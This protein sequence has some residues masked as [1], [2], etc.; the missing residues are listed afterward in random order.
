MTNLLKNN[1]L[2]YS[3]ASLTVPI[4]SVQTNS[5]ILTNQIISA[6]H[7]FSYTIP[8]NSFT[9]DTLR[10]SISQADGSALPSWLHFDSTT[11]TLSGTP[12]EG[13][14]GTLNLKVTATDN[15]NA[16]VSSI[17][18]VTAID[19][20]PT[21]SLNGDGLITTDFNSADDV[22]VSTKIQADGKIIIAGYSYVGSHW[23]LALARYNTDGSL[24]TSFN[25]NGK[26]TTAIG[27]TDTYGYSVSI[28]ADGKILLA[29]DNYNGSTDSFALA[30]YNTDGSLDTSFNGNGIVTTTIGTNG[31]WANSVTTQTD[32]KILLAGN[33]LDNNYAIVLARFNSDGTLDASFNG[34]GVVKTAIGTSDN[35]GC[36][37]NLQADGKMLVVGYS[38]NGSK[39]GFALACYNGDG[40]LDTSFNATGEIITTIGTADAYAYASTLQSDGKILVAG[41]T[42]NGSNWDFALVRYN[43]D[44]SLDASFNGNGIVT[45]AIGSADDSAESIT[46][47]TDGKILVAGISNN[48]SS[49]DFALVRYNSDGSL[50]TTFNDTG[51]VTSDFGKQYAR[52]YSVTVQADGEILVAGRSS[53]GSNRDF[54][55]ARYNPD[56]TLDTS[57]HAVNTL[58][59]AN[60]LYT[61]NSVPVVLDSTVQIQDAELNAVGNYAGASITL[62][63]HG[64]ADSQDIF[65]ATGNLS[66]DGSNVLLSGVNIGVVSNSNGLLQVVFNANATQALVNQ[67]LSALAYSSNASNLPPSIQIDWTFNDGNSGAQGAG[68]TQSVTGISTVTINAPPSDILLDNNSVD[69]YSANGTVIGLLS[70][71]DKDA[72]QSH[73]LK[74]LDDAGGS[75]VL[76]GNK[77]VVANAALLDYESN[78]NPVVKIL[79][80]DSGGLS[81]EKDITIHINPFDADLVVSNIADVASPGS[82]YAGTYVDISWTDQNQYNSNFNGTWTDNVYLEDTNNPGQDR[83]LG[84]YNLTA[85]LLQGVALNRTQSVYLP[86]DL[87]GAYQL[88]VV[89]DANNQVKEGVAGEVNNRTVGS[90][91]FNIHPALSPNLQVSSVSAP[92]TIFAGKQTSIQ[93]TVTNSGTA[94]TNAPYWQDKVWLSLDKNLDG[95]DILLGTAN[96]PAYLNI[97]DSYTNQLNIN[98]PYTALGNYYVIVQTDAGNQIQEVGH[99]NDNANASNVMQVNPVPISDL[100]DLTVPNVSAPLQAFS[101]QQMLVGYQIGNQGQANLPD[102]AFAAANGLPTGEFTTS[103]PDLI[104]AQPEAQIKVYMSS[105]NTLSTDDLLLATQTLDMKYIKDL[106]VTY[107][108]DGNPVYH[109]QYINNAPLALGKSNFSGTVA[110]NLP[111]GVSGDFYYLVSLQNL[112]GPDAQTN[113]KSGISSAVHVVL[114]PPPDLEITGLTAPTSGNAGHQININYQVDNAGLTIT[115]NSS[116]IDQFYLSTTPTLASDAISLGSSIH[117]G[118][119]EV[120]GTYQGTVTFT[121]PTDLIGSYYLIAQTDSTNQVFEQNKVNNVT[122]IPINLVSQQP[123]LVV[124]NVV[125]DTNLFAGQ[126]VQVSWTVSNQGSGDTFPDSWQDTVVLSRDSI[127]GNADDIVLQSFTHT[128][129]L[130]P[131]QSYKQS[132]L[133]SLPAAASG[134]YYVFVQTDSSNNVFEG[135]NEQNNQLLANL[136]NTGQAT[137]LTV[138]SASADLKV[139]DIVVP[140][141]TA[142]GSF[143]NVSWTVANTGNASTN[144]NGW[145]DKIILSSDDT[146]GNADDIALGSVYRDNSLGVGESY[147]A[148]TNLLLPTALSGNYHVFVVA[149]SAHQVYEVGGHSDNVTEAQAVLSVAQTSLPD[150]QIT[151]L[152]VPATGLSTQTL[153]I[154]WTVTNN[155][156]A[157]LG[158]SDPAN[159]L[160]ATTRRDAFYLSRDQVLD[161]STDIYLGQAENPAALASGLSQTYSSSF[162][163]PRGLSGNY[164]LIAVTDNNNHLFEGSGE[165][166]NVTPSPNPIAI[167]LPPPADLAVENITIPANGLAGQQTSVQYTV[168][169]LSGET[170][171]GSWQDTLYLSKDNQW[172]I[173]DPVFAQVTHNGDLTVG[174]SY[175]GTV[176][177]FLPGVIPD[178]YHIIVRNDTLNNV[179]DLNRQNNLAASSDTINVDVN[180]LSLGV[181]ASGEI[182]QGQSVYY[183]LN[184]SAGQ[185]LDVDLKN[186]TQQG[187][188]ELYVSYNQMPTRT[189]F[190]YSYN[191][192]SG[193]EQTAVVPN[194]QSGTYYI[195]AYG[196]EITNSIDHTQPNTAAYTLSADLAHYGVTSISTNAGSNLGETTLR[197]TGTL[198]SPVSVASLVAADGTQISAKQVIWKN[199]TEIWATFDLK[200]QSIGNYDVK[201]SDGVN[202]ASLAHAFTV[203]HN[204]AGHLDISMELPSVLRPYQEGTARI[205]YRNTGSTDISAPLLTLSGDALLKLPSDKQYGGSS[206]ELL[207][208]NTDGPAGVIPP[209]GVGTITVNFKPFAVDAHT[210]VTLTISTLTPNAVQDWNTLLEN[211]KP[212]D[213]DFKSW[214]QIKANLIAEIGPTTDSYQQALNLAAN[215]LAQLGESTNDVKK[216]FALLYNE[217]SNNGALLHSATI[218][219]LGRDHLFKWDNNAIRQS[220]GDVKITVS[221]VA[222]QFTHQTDGRYVG[223]ASDTLTENTGVLTFRR[224]D[225][226]EIVFNPDGSFNTLTDTNGIVWHA[227]YSGTLLTSVS[228][229][230]GNSEAFTYNDQGRIK[231]ITDQANQTTIFGY[232]PSGLFQ[233]SVTTASGTTQYQY[234]TDGGAAQGQIKEIISPDGTVQH[235]NY[236]NQGRLY[237]ESLNND[238]ISETYHY[239]GV[240]EVDITD[241]KGATRKY[242]YNDQKQIA[243]IE[244]A[245]GNIN[246]LSYDSNG[247]I[248]NV[249]TSD[250]AVPARI[251]QTLSNSSAKINTLQ[252][253]NNQALNVATPTKYGYFPYPLPSVDI[254]KDTIT[255]FDIRDWGDKN[256]VLIAGFKQFYLNLVGALLQKGT[257]LEHATITVTLNIHSAQI[258]TF[259][260]SNNIILAVDPNNLYVNDLAAG[261]TQAQAQ[262]DVINEAVN[263]LV[264]DFLGTTEALAKSN[265]IVGSRGLVALD[266]LEVGIVP[267]S[268]AEAGAT[269]AF[270]SLIIASLELQ[271]ATYIAWKAEMAIINA[272]INNF[273]GVGNSVTL[274][275]YDKLNNKVSGLYFPD[276]LG[277]LGNDPYR[278]ATE[279][280][281]AQAKSEIDHNGGY[282]G[283]LDS[284]EAIYDPFG[285]GPIVNHKFEIY[286]GNFIINLL[287]LI[288]LN[289]GEFLNLS[290]KKNLNAHVGKNGEDYFIFDATAPYQNYYTSLDFKL[291]IGDSF[292]IYTV[293]NI[294]KN[295]AE[296]KDLMLGKGTGGVDL[297]YDENLNSASVLKSSGDNAIV[298]GGSANDVIYGHGKNNV[299][300]GNGGDDTFDMI[301][302]GDGT[303]VDGGQGTDKIEFSSQSHDVN[304]NLS[305]NLAYVKNSF[306][307]DNYTI[308]NVEDVTT[309]SGNDFVKG[310]V[311][312]SNVIKT[313]DGDDTLIGG[314]GD[315]DSHDTLNGGNGDDTYY[316]TSG[317]N[318]KDSDG[319]GKVYLDNE[320]L[321]GGDWQ[322]NINAFSDGKF[323]YVVK[324]D[325]ILIISDAGVTIISAHVDKSELL[326]GVTIYRTLGIELVKEKNPPTPPTPEPPK[327]LPKDPEP[328]QPIPILTPGD[329]NDIIGPQGYGDQNWLKAGATEDYTINFEN[330]STA[331]APAQQVTITE[332]LDPNLDINSFRLGDFGWG[333]ITVHVPTNASFYNERLDYS[334]KGYLL[335]VTAGIDVAKR[336]VFWTFT[337]LDPST[338]APTTNPLLG[339]L[340][341]NNDQGIGNAFV[342]YSISPNQKVTT[343]TSIQSKATIVFDTQPAM[344]TPTVAYTLDNTAPA[345]KLSATPIVGSDP[346]VNDYQ[347]TWSG[348][349]TGSA[350]ASYTL[351]VSDNGGAYKP[352]L[353]NSVLTQAVYHGQTGHNYA[354]YSI[355]V[356]NA[357]NQEA[358]PSAPQIAKVEPILA[359]R[360]AVGDNMDITVHFNK[361]VIVQAGNLAPA[362]SLAIGSGQ[363]NADYLSGSGTD[364]LVFRH[365]VQAGEYSTNGLS[366]GHA[367]VLNGSNI[368]D[369]AGNSADLNLGT[370]SVSGVSV[371]NAPLLTINGAAQT[372]EGSD[373][374]LSI[375]T[376]DADTG[377]QGLNLSIDWGDGSTQTLSTSA[378]AATNGVTDHVFTD[379]NNTAKPTKYNIQITASDPLGV[380]TIQNQ[381]ITVNN[382]A[383][384]IALSGNAK[385][386]QGQA[387]QLTLGNIIDPGQDTVSQITVHWGDG[388]Q[389]IYP[390]V[391]TVSHFYNTSA[392]NQIS[393]D[394]TDEDGQYTNVAHLNVAVNAVG[395]VVNFLSNLNTISNRSFSINDSSVNIANNLNA[396]ETNYS[397]INSITSFDNTVITLTAAQLTADKDVLALLSPSNYRLKVTGILVANVHTV[398]ANT[399]VTALTVMGVS[400]AN[401]DTATLGLLAKVSSI[402]L[403]SG[404]TSLTYAEYANANGKL[405]ST[406]LTITGVSVANAATVAADSHVAHLTLAGTALTAAQ[407]TS[408]VSTKNTTSGLT[409]TGVSV[410]NASTSSALVKDN[411]VTAIAVT[412]ATAINLDK[413]SLGLQTKVTS[414]TL[415]SGVTSLTYFEYS[416]A[417]GKLATSGI[418]IKGVPAANAAT[419]AGNTHV[420][421]ITLAG[422]ALKAVQYTSAVSAKNTT[423][424]LTINSVSVANASNLATDSHVASINVTGVSAT[425]LDTTTL[426]ALPKVT[427]IT[428]ATGVASL[429]YAEYVNAK[430]KLASTGLTITGV[431]VANAVAASTVVKDSHVAAITVIG[432]T[433]ANLDKTTLGA[434]SKVTSIA[435]VSGVTRLTSAEYANANGKLVSSGLIITGV[436]VA[437]AATVAADSHV[438]H[439]TLAGTALTAIQYISAVSTKNTTTGLTITGVDMTNA[440]IVAADSHVTSITVTGVGTTNLDTT[441][442]GALPKVTSI[443]LATGVAS[444]NYAEYV[445]AKG[446]LASTGLTITGVSV[447]NGVAT[448]TVIKDSHV[449]AITVNDTAA[450]IT[451]NL[452][453]L[454]T[455]TKLSSITLI[456]PTTALSITAVQSSANHAVLAKI[457]GAYNS[458]ITGTNV[459][460]KLFDTVN[461]HATLTGGKGIDTFNVTGTDTITDLG[462]GGAD[463]LIVAKGGITNSTINTAWI[464][465]A[466]TINNGTA[467]ISTAG[468]TV[469]LSAVTKGTSGYKIIDTGSATKLTGSALADLIIGGTGNDTLTGGKGNDVF[470]FNTKPNNTTNVDLITDFT[471]GKDHLQLGKSIFTGIFTVAGTGDGRTLAGTEFVSS[472]TATHGTTANSHLIYN[473]ATGALYYDADGNAK[474]AAI[475]VAILGTTTH[476]VLTASD[477]LII[478]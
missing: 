429:N 384:S 205:I 179:G 404:V 434:Q 190:D 114:T 78:P 118:S 444:L 255:A 66:F 361:S 79:S 111:T 451:A 192:L 164:Y 423:T 187:F 161:P 420:S 424:G 243:Q 358:G 156:A 154:G 232:D 143:L 282:L 309:G 377:N 230:N 370:I 459:A 115:P 196:Q 146:L 405:A 350:I 34:N 236:D 363:V 298:I 122:E 158:Q 455:N 38:N 275:F 425:N 372:P 253:T 265:I 250:S 334:T 45:T 182:S 297:I 380:Q 296:Q 85:R 181:A 116:W 323:N 354:F 186:L 234:V 49:D 23:S 364:T 125:S 216:L 436:S 165:N 408:A 403:A 353:Q 200:G 120:R 417:N 137:P 252:Q 126:G 256:P 450:H 371:D 81:F 142:S 131:G 413:S 367:I 241:T 228:A 207:G 355:A 428:L 224:Q 303:I 41:E 134:N 218:G 127:L 310:Q 57:F 202:S 347:V 438:A 294:Y 393:V 421:H 61:E 318:I 477:I 433:T 332:A 365:T 291:N 178:G 4:N 13:I 84:S 48:G 264:G 184:V 274:D 304:V 28:Q 44:G 213:I 86:T 330:K 5:D 68:G 427:S 430:G 239:V 349:D 121:L 168:T 376:S 320:L 406:G 307:N 212:L 326:N 340:P 129:K 40:S 51:I 251:N 258:S 108:S 10:Y 46:V 72:G 109:W 382:V 422:T 390:G 400:T 3:S 272:T 426:G 183:K 113:D 335:D 105:D 415:A 1:I 195:L 201:M 414:I 222:V 50:D 27:V 337:T 139:S 208:I 245:S 75:F 440:A 283:N 77:L 449:A 149:D 369:L 136:S 193:S 442:L 103:T 321:K 273:Y 30:R 17:F 133:L 240:N 342:Q 472:K 97:G 301:D 188:T 36:S 52:A 117:N 249:I 270:S 284:S 366:I 397:K 135:I 435:L 62:M 313:N 454:L 244:D 328:P 419:V 471:S 175:T 314:A 60:V 319:N 67:A 295:I 386:D 394:L 16:S 100:A 56:G 247:N 292:K 55:L 387:Y 468:L 63:R 9:G 352:W 412:G 458:T 54:A 474:G 411:H 431:S 447:A 437:N 194:T 189:H 96:N 39:Y 80:T 26:V 227:T 229:S 172:D 389:D 144:V 58:A 322:D 162:N 475:E 316:A 362:I 302:S 95:G 2:K 203:N 288:Q 407:Y 92:D 439:L 345:S 160:D 463:I 348:Q 237:T 93:W 308:Y 152:Q 233:T 87:N 248:T 259:L 141:N 83:L 170:A 104:S 128:G 209:G 82:V 276:G 392:N 24:D 351:Y 151:G 356:D 98:I 373:Y 64:G 311:G 33:S 325:G 281:I 383:P 432:A 331:T 457:A 14:Y 261:K 465:S 22:G 293:N 197:I 206:L 15:A 145:N 402:T 445:N 368:H 443:T 6:H 418:S 7:A 446:K 226:T 76:D 174:A 289:I 285:V 336:Q 25:G 101:G 102:D 287:S 53:N 155:G 456:D 159:G 246:K 211:S 65:S 8:A 452:S 381:H 379:G 359:G 132:E 278:V 467:N 466:D 357:G 416:N 35:F 217:A 300:I 220:N 254:T 476:P 74:L 21:F 401:L 59:N 317:D 324:N 88:V 267:V 305:S 460:D 391:D 12:S 163:I 31:G 473:T 409:I 19:T 70:T 191:N 71:V 147:Q 338:G 286:D 333:N 306:F 469:N 271:A 315:S 238:P 112:A 231:Q 344:D 269:L 378:L 123:D 215:A 290:D 329:P 94:A 167:S 263:V 360:Y 106:G 140:S 91:V 441:T 204:T 73:T 173:N 470:V 395:N 341:V 90:Q 268:I 399:H 277:G 279:D 343:G 32:G 210:S 176:S 225:G 180:S 69:E 20:A 11:R 110:V 43:T 198:L 462:K 396:L 478:A 89:T 18:T 169:N 461:S 299:L 260:Q 37:V 223:T 464:A 346:N 47:Q 235:F 257:I 153:Q 242:W 171:Q 410:D 107:G 221:G 398:L 280:F 199:S 29:G 157:I 177:G 375:Q 262:A 124:T 219:V 266:I 148:A 374:Q 448:S 138:Q 119:L 150:V 388:T 130:N 42:Y 339:F 214:M 166:N 327:P 99:E 453:A 185:T 312:I 385:V